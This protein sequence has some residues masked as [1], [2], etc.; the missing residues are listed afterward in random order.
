MVILN[1]RRFV[2]TAAAGLVGAGLS[3]S[4]AG[5]N[6]LPKRKFWMNLHPRLV[7]VKAMAPE[8]IKLAAKYGYQ[9][10][11]PVPEYLNGLSEGEQDELLAKL[12]AAG[13]KWGTATIR[14]FFRSDESEF[15]ETKR[16]VL[17]WAKMLQRLGVTR[18]LTWT[19][20]SSNS[21][22]FVANFRHHQRRLREVGKIL[23]DH[24]LRIGVEYLGTRT[25]GGRYKY[26]FVRSL[27]GMKELTDETGLDNVGLCLDAWHWYQAGDTEE[28]ILR[29]TNRELVN[30]DICDAPK[31]IPRE[32][33]PDSPRELPCATGVIDIKAFLT[34]L[35]KV[36][37]DG[38]V[39]SE[40]FDK[41]LATMSTEDAM[42]AASTAMKKAFAL[43]E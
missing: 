25:L 10:I 27:A 16:K 40:P 3:A 37:Y 13:L 4:R 38:P 22:T 35:L 11:V 36:G 7:G 12:K 32:R 6:D 39:G 21:L 9:S 33:M 29:L 19:M 1:R 34:G 31:G 17:G 24:E 8:A 20:C 15:G 26:P 43:I 30:A 41:S 28:D 23:A 14:P 42:T 5:A 2:Q 18:C